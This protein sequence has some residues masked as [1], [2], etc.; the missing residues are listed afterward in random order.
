MAKNGLW[1]MLPLVGIALVATGCRFKSY[2]SYVNTTTPLDNPAQ[3]GDPYAVGSNAEAS[4]GQ[5][6]SSSYPTDVARPQAPRP[7]IE[8]GEGRVPV[9]VQPVGAGGP[10]PARPGRQGQNFEQ[11]DPGAAGGTGQAGDDGTAAPGQAN[12]GT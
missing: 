9:Q 4:G 2:E 5:D 8:S 6:P 10:A 7:L 3:Y 1:R 11:M 12:P